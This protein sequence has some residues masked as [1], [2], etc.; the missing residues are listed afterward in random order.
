MLQQRQCFFAAAVEEALFLGCQTGGADRFQESL[1]LGSIL[2]EK[3]GEDAFG[4]IELTAP[5]QH[6]GVTQLVAVPLLGFQLRA[7]AFERGIALQSV[8]G[9]LEDILRLFEVAI[10]KT[11]MYV[12]DCLLDLGAAQADRDF[13]TQVLQLR[14]PG[15]FDLRVLHEREGLAPCTRANLL[16]DQFDAP[17][18]LFVALMIRQVDTDALGGLAQCGVGGIGL[19]SLFDHRERGLP[20]LELL[21]SLRASEGIL[22]VA[23]LLP[24]G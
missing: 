15:E 24:F 17:R 4:L 8:E 10:G 12:R 11:F 23:A 2:V 7:Q 18:Q 16:L 9:A 19:Q 6:L 1:N 20:L 5:K 3:C 21:E 13:P 14:G 22:R